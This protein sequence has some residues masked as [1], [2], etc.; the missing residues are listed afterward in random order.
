MFESGLFYH[1]LC[2]ASYLD[3]K[4]ACV[5]KAEKKDWHEAKC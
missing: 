4:C 2:F 5:S 3:F 1:Y